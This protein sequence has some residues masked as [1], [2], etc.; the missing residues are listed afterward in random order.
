M[1]AETPRRKRTPLRCLLVDDHPAVLEALTELLEA[2]GIA[3]V[4]RAYTGAEA[5]PLAR[6]VDAVVVTDLSLPDMTGL[7]VAEEILRTEP[8]RAIVLYAA[9]ITAARVTKALELGVRGVVLTDS[10][11]VALAPAIRAAAAGGSFVDP[12]I[13]R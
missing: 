12:R 11:P 4:G 9:T 13:R 8:G 3:V 10:A 5:I 6:S 1:G 7:E 2:E